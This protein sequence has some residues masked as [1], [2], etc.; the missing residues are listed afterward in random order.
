MKAPQVSVVVPAYNAARYLPRTLASIVAQEGVD[1]EVLVVDDGSRDGTADIVRAFAGPAL[2]YLPQQPSGGPAR[3]RNVGIGEA[4]G[5]L[6]ALCDADD[7]ML[8]G[9][10]AAAVAV[11]AARPEVDLV[12]T[13]FAAIDA[14]DKV[15]RPRYLEQYQRFRQALQPTDL[16]DVG[17]LA[18]RVLYEQLLHANFVG[19]SSVVM[20]RRTALAVGGFDETLRN[21]DDYDLWCR[22]AWSGATFAFIDAVHHQYRLHGGNLSKKT[23]MRKPAAIKVWEKQRALALD[24]KERRQVELRL[25]GLY[26]GYA[27]GLRQEGNRADAIV[28]YRRAWRECRSLRAM[29]G[30]VRTLI[31]RSA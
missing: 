27:D 4:A 18:G 19:T 30:F 15:L 17:L 31:M 14:D 16:P 24:Q 29:I 12:H 11:F 13:D 7:V 26:L 9:K 10:L 6:V 28:A 1:L 2:R 25:R 8:P 21:A 20:R 5:E 23:T 3:P 22:L